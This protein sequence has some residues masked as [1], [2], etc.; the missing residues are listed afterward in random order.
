M[1]SKAK[2]ML[3]IL[4]ALLLAM[5]AMASA[6]GDDALVIPPEL[7][8]GL[9]GL[10]GPAGDLPTDALALEG[11][12][13]SGDLTVDGLLFE[14]TEA[15]DNEAEVVPE[16]PE[17]EAATEAASLA[18]YAELEGVTFA[19]YADAGVLPADA[20]LRVAQQEDVAEAF[21]EAI[22]DKAKHR[23]YRI[24]ALD[25]EGYA[26]APEV[27]ADAATVRVSGLDLSG[28]ICVAWY[29]AIGETACPLAVDASGDE[30]TF[31]FMAST[32]YD[33]ATVMEEIARSRP[34]KD[35][36]G[37]TRRGGR[38][39]A[40]PSGEGGPAGGWAGRGPRRC[41]KRL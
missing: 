34:Q 5:P 41:D 27:A 14:G 18:L 3:A 16:A 37:P 7:N 11:I 13:L 12:D 29:D 40:F 22:G 38:C 24:E 20:T 23:V 8:E 32:V 1:K 33:I 35:A 6:E 17:G 10:D 25:G 19:L 21:L 31:A 26:I 4:L 36:G 2:R 9:E 28:E 30:I 15:A 39:T